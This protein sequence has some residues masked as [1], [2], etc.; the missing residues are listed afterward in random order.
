MNIQLAH[1]AI[2]RLEVAV[3]VFW[4]EDPHFQWDGDCEE[5]ADM[6][7]YIVEV[8]A[9]RIRKGQL[10]TGHAYLSGCY[11]ADAGKDDPEIGGYLSQMI[12]EAIAGLLDG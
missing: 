12:D 3:E 11:S 10:E 8:R 6:S 4:T 7:P 2:V 5:P 1:I 9:S